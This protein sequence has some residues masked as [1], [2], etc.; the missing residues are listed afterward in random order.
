MVAAAANAEWEAGV[1][2][3]QQGNYTQAIQELQQVTAE[4]P[5]WADGHWMLGSA[6]LKAGRTSDAVTSLRRAYDL[7]PSTKM[8]F[9]LGQAYVAA[10]QYA[11]GSTI[12]TKMDTSVLSASQQAVHSQLLAKALAESG[13]TDRAVAELA[14]AAQ[15]KPN[16]AAVQFQYGAAA[17]NAGD[18]AAA[19][20]ALGRAAELD[21]SPDVLRALTKAYIRQGRESQGDAKL[22]AYRRAT[23]SASSLVA[24]DG[25]AANVMLLG[26]AQLGGRQYN[27]AAATFQKAAGMDARDWLPQY[28]LGQAYTAAGVYD[29]AEAP[30]RRALELTSASADQVK[31][32]GQLGFVFEKQRSWDEAKAAYGRAGNQ[33]AIQR[34]ATNQETAE[35]NQEVEQYNQTI[36][37]LESEREALERELQGLPGSG[38]SDDDD[39]DDDPPA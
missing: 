2:A 17:L 32:W 35:H 7:D 38:S 18:T 6:Q 34:V 19:V 29:R 39:D 16:D 28:Y 33:A 5:E 24:A 36:E 21:S 9:A 25:S 15:G 26:E 37:E 13:Q 4:N 14:K 30:L 3:F 8:Q 10:G 31:I 11:D 12:L 22:A 27:E 1:Q 23:Q 20:R